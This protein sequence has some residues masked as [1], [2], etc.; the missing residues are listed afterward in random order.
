[1]IGL[2][3]GP[4]STLF[5]SIYLIQAWLEK[6][7]GVYFFLYFTAVSAMN[8]SR[9]L[10]YFPTASTFALEE[11]GPLLPLLR[12]GGVLLRR[13]YWLVGFFKKKRRK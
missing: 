6:V 13:V 10:S 12:G 11:Q 4:G 1:M 2:S 7:G 5:Y 8:C 3:A 9:R